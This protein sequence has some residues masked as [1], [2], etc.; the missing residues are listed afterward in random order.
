MFPQ[1]EV[2]PFLDCEPEQFSSEAE[3][4]ENSRRPWRA[5][6]PPA[7]GSAIFQH[8]ITNFPQALLW[9]FDSSK[10]FDRPWQIWTKSTRGKQGKS[11]VV[12]L[13]PVDAGASGKFFVVIFFSAETTMEIEISRD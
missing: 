7:P 8:L 3:E 13:P 6:W 12:E 10:P 5:Y 9:R 2:P 1:I 4:S 11:S